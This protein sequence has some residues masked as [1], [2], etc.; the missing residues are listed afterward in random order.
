VVI[1]LDNLDDGQSND[2][3]PLNHGTQIRYAD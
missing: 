2:L 3:P 1:L